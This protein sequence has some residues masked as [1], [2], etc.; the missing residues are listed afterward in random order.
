MKE[1]NYH[2]EKFRVFKSEGTWKWA[3]GMARSLLAP[4]KLKPFTEDMF[5]R[6]YV[7][8]DKGLPP[9]RVYRR[10]REKET[11][12]V[13]AYFEDHL[14]VQHDFDEATSRNFS[15]APYEQNVVFT[16]D[17]AR[18]RRKYRLTNFCN[19]GASARHGGLDAHSSFPDKQYGY[20][21][22]VQEKYNIDFAVNRQRARELLCRKGNAYTTKLQTV[23]N[24]SEFRQV[25][26][27]RPTNF[28]ANLTTH[29]RDYED[30]KARFDRLVRAEVENMN[31]GI[32]FLGHEIVSK[33]S[34]SRVEEF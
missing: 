19:T 32:V 14:L 3:E 8:C 20:V 21:N 26:M 31:Q 9:M 29:F 17:V 10:A 34:Q 28:S 5:T 27:N 2:D 11:D 15:E 1:E 24:L 13:V 30:N 23:N 6:S 25:R 18:Q 7:V 4:G 12:K 16:D 22:A 33:S